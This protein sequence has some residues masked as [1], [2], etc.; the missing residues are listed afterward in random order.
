MTHWDDLRRHQAGIR[1][2]A[3]LS[4]FD[5]PARA[6]GFAAETDGMLLDY[7]KTN[8]DAK[9]R[10]LLIALAKGAG[11]ADRRAAMFSGAKINETEGRAVLHTAL[12]N[13]DTPV[14]VDGRDVLP[15]VRATLAR[16]EAF[17]RDLREG[18]LRGQGGAITDVV[19]IGI[20]GSDLGPAMACLALSPYADGP[21]THFVS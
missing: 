6:S 16:M 2:R 20:G 12:R 18:R 7:S 1:D 15:E 8:I 14:I 5:D 11:V 4:L 10:D 3:I 21:R 13:L 17:A 9:A 19:N